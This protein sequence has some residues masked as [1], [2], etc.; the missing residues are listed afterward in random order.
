MRLRRFKPTNGRRYSEIAEPAFLETAHNVAMAAEK[1]DMITFEVVEP[2]LLLMIN[3]GAQQTHERIDLFRALVDR[4]AEPKRVYKGEMARVKGKE[5][6]TY[7]EYVGD[8]WPAVT[9]DK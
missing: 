3:G 9:E 4:E 2:S 1:V 6:T 7:Y 5:D 8:G